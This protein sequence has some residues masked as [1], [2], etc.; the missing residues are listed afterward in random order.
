MQPFISICSCKR[1]GF[2]GIDTPAVNNGWVSSAVFLSKPMGKAL[3]LVYYKG[4]T[5]DADVLQ[6]IIK[7]DLFFSWLFSSF[8]KP[9]TDPEIKDLR[10]SLAPVS[11]FKIR[12]IYFRPLALTF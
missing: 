1:L 5:S 3:G 4:I 10:I 2:S 11:L 6:V 9:V 8:P 12:G 7:F